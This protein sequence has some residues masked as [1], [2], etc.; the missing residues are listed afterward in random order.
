[1]QKNKTLNHIKELRK[2]FSQF[3]DETQDIIY[4]QIDTKITDSNISKQSPQIK[5]PNILNS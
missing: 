2:K 4:P 3:Q 1:M 5:E